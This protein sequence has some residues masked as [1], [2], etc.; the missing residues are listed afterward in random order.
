MKT[1]KKKKF[2]IERIENKATTSR[3]KA[4]KISVNKNK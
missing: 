3:F 1:C 4:A 2:K